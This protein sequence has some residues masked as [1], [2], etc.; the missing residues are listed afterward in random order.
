MISVTP[1]CHTHSRH[2][3]VDSP[4]SQDHD[5]AKNEVSH[6]GRN[7]QIVQSCQNVHCQYWNGWHGVACRIQCHVMCH[8]H[9]VASAACV[10]SCH[11]PLFFRN[12]LLESALLSQD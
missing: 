5:K 12:A 7:V 2:V 11:I 8:V 6:S 3:S 1:S 10:T 4:V 9:H